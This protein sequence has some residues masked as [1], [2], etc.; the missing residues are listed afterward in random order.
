MSIRRNRLMIAN[1]ATTDVWKIPLT[2]KA[3]AA[4]AGLYI[5]Y[6]T[7]IDST[8]LPVDD[9]FYR[10]GTGGPWLPLAPEEILIAPEDGW[11][12][13]LYCS[14]DFF[15]NSTVA[16]GMRK[17]SRGSG[18]WDVTGDVTSL[19]NFSEKLGNACL[20]NALQGTRSWS[21]AFY[22]DVTIGATELTGYYCLNGLFTGTAENSWYLTPIK[23][24]KVRFTDWGSSR[25]V[26][27]MRNVESGGTFI[28]P[29]A[30]QTEYGVSRIPEDWTVVDY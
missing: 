24:V 21:S 23:A 1:S 15:S 6:A 26:N 22:F 19:C 8:N 11:I 2:F 16:A 30:L 17:I 5:H 10:V 12:V 25:T 28:K 3:R 18:S 20:N 13:Q 9:L 7:A 27:W 14:S 4:G 29:R